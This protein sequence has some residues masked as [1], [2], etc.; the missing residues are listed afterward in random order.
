LEKTLENFENELFQNDLINDPGS[1]AEFVEKVKLS[2]NGKLITIE[3][4]EE[5]KICDR[6]K[7]VYES[8]GRFYDLLYFYQ[9]IYEH[10]I[11]Y[12]IKQKERIH[13][14]MPLVFIAQ[15][16]HGFGY[17]ALAKRYFMLTFIEDVISYDGK[18]DKRKAGS[19]SYL[20]WWY[21]LPDID[22]DRYQT[23]IFDK[24]KSQ[25]EEY[26]FPEA[27]I[28]ELDKDW[29]IETPTPQE[30]MIYVI[31][32]A[33]VQWL[34]K[35]LGGGTG[36]ILERLAEYLLFCIPGCRTARR[37][38]TKSS[39][40]DIVC[41]L[42]GDNLDFRSE[43]GR[44]FICECKDEKDPV[45][46]TSMAKFAYMLQS[47]KAGFGIMFALKGISGENKQVYAARIPLQVYSDV[48]T[49]IVVVDKKDIN[50]VSK[51]RNL[52]TLLRKK[53][54]QVRLDIR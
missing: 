27:L 11:R 16:Y 7:K 37:I 35:K 33:Y 41:S 1:V 30:S 43:F 2:L 5:R 47:I 42:E 53:Y 9:E 4:S 51:G 6:V 8:Q 48:G 52:I 20:R 17:Y 44:Y 18:I 29:L 15:Y 23:N 14:G 12:Q 34:I 28:M 40:Y 3:N 25:N 13:K 36:K 32:R 54:E 50:D 31:N 39:E 21:G 24:F 26:N 38:Q 10:L 45:N 46:I 19:Y 49:I 22:I